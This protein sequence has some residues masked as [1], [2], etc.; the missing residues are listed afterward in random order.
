MTVDE[1]RHAF[2]SPDVEAAFQR[3]VDDRKARARAYEHRPAVG[4]KLFEPGR[5]DPVT[6]SYV[7]VYRLLGIRTLLPMPRVFIQG[8]RWRRCLMTYRTNTGRIAHHPR[9]YDFADDVRELVCEPIR[10]DVYAMW[11]DPKERW[12]R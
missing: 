6:G 5:R 10:G 4:G 3:W 9:V 2:V 8:P 7:H 1:A 11:S 12:G